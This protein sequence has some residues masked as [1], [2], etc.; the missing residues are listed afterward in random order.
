MNKEFKIRKSW[1][2]VGAGKQLAIGISV[3][4]YS[5]NI[6]LFCFWITIEF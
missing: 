3:S 1:V 4:K 2:S 5:F 6:D